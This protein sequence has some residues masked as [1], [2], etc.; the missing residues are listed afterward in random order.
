MNK[1]IEHNPEEGSHYCDRNYTSFS[2]TINLAGPIRKILK[3]RTFD[4][5]PK[6]DAGGHL[7]E[8]TTSLDKLTDTPS[9]LN[10]LSLFSSCFA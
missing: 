10:L 6:A 7:I 9:T 5:F 2:L 8:S 4:L 1:L 3:C